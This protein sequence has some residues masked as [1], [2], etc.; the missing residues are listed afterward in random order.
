MPICAV[1][2]L[3]TSKKMLAIYTKSGDGGFLEG[4]LMT[5]IQDRAWRVLL[6]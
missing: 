6:L 5:V 4:A 2:L 3:K 1:R